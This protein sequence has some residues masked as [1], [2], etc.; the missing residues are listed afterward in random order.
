MN[1]PIN[2]P[3]ATVSATV[4]APS[5]APASPAVATATIGVVVAFAANPAKLSPAFLRDT[6][7]ARMRRDLGADAIRTTTTTDSK[8]KTK[9]TTAMI[10]RDLLPDVVSPAAALGVA[11]GVAVVGASGSTPATRWIHVG[12]KEG[13]SR[14]IYTLAS[15]SDAAVD[16]RG[17]AGAEAR[18]DGSLIIDPAIPAPIA[19]ALRAAYDDARGVVEPSRVNAAIARYLQGRSAQQLTASTYLVPQDDRELSAVL[20]AIVDLGGFAGCYPVANGANAAAL[21]QPVTRS[22][23]D[24]VAAVLAA[25]RDTIDRA[26]AAALPS[27]DKLAFRDS[28]ADTAHAAIDEV[29]AKLALWRDRLGV[30]LADVDETLNDADQTL[31]VACDAA[32]KAV[33]ARK[34][35][36][37]AAAAS[38]NA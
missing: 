20:A 11:V 21:V 24:D 25:A 30:V 18:P 27:S 35:A 1:A 23:A 5:T 14:W 19:T 17:T 37:A 26:K 29:R 15:V 33:A 32:L 10:F 8:G 38:A 9:T 3:P 28:N 7:E 2:T 6:V 4:S 31:D 16:I 13:V 12:Q 22:L 36:R 34:A